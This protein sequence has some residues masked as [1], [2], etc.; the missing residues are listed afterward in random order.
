[1]GFCKN[2][3]NNILRGRVKTEGKNERARERE[4][5]NNYAKH[6]WKCNVV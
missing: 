4:K 3:I 5:Q 6:Q 1:M 2:K